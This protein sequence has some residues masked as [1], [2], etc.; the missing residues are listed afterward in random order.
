MMKKLPGVTPQQEARIEAAPACFLMS[1]YDGT[2]APFRL[3][4]REAVPAASVVEL[5][6]R[7]SVG[8]KT[9]LA[10]VSGR[11][12]EDLGRLLG[13]LPIHVVGEHGWE[14]RLPGGTMI[15]HPLDHHVAAALARALARASARAW[16]DRLERKRTSI[17]LHTRGLPS[18][19][20]DR[21][22]TDCAKLWEV[23]TEESGLWLRRAGGGIELRA[24]GRN[25]GTAVKELLDTCAPGTLG[26]Y[27][28]DDETDED[29][30]AALLPD[31]I[32]L[33]VSPSDRPSFATGRLFTPADV[34]AF[35][36]SWLLLVEGV[37]GPMARSS[38]IPEQP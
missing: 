12:V 23:E 19:Q 24:P 29:A 20:A 1:D 22:E 32:G 37:A 17:M 21:I 10:V 4:W 34:Q 36:E 28:G 15:S 33:L 13:P 26:V 18:D 9:T 16:A 7:L 38:H 11:P 2:L 35:L 30:F 3:D 8:R 31:G 25:K 5:L 6:A 14:C 27:L